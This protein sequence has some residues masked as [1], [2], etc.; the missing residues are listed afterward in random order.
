MENNLIKNHTG[1]NFLMR[2]KFILNI[3]PATGEP[4]DKIKCSSPG[5]VASAVKLA[6]K[7]FKTW[8]FFTLSQ[9]IAYFK[10]ILKDLIAEKNNISRLITDEMGKVFKQS[11]IE[12]DDMIDSFRDT[13]DMVE[14]SFSM[15]Q[16]K[17]K[18][19]ISEIHRIPIG[20]A[21]II[22]PW[23]FP[24]AMPE[25]LLT[26]SILAGNTVVFKPSECTPLTGKAIFEVFHRYLPKGVI[27]LV[28][29]AD[30]VGECLIN[31]DID[32]IA[33]IGSQEV[34]KKI[35]QTAS[36]KLNRVILELGG[37]DP[38]IV[39]KDAN[40]RKAAEF[41]VKNSISNS[42]QVCVSV[43]RI[44]VDERI[45]HKFEKEVLSI[46][47]DVKVGSG[48]ENVDIGPMVNEIQRA[49]VIS[50]IEEARRKGGKLL[51]GGNIINRKGYFMEPTVLTNLTEKHDI[52]KEETF[53]PVVCI[54]KYRTIEEAI[55]KA[56][57]T[58]F[59]LGATIWTESH[60]KAI[61]IANKIEAGMIGI[62]KSVC[63]VKRTPW[64]GIKESGYG[65]LGSIEGLR[66]FTLPKKISYYIK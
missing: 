23:N 18:K 36:R 56:N 58:T 64:I 20:V 11:Q 52:M 45:A 1:I 14:E 39:M 15:T 37:K 38:M 34:G 27:N 47:K 49:H 66:Q 30:E 44:Y 17:H 59:G 42:G 12:F 26:P 5:E 32:M 3:N 16:Y 9:R 31:S 35:M 6:K 2:Q 50:Q 4:I 55:E 46:I 62:N 28:Q 7:A 25:W 65:F 57:N 54:Q 29:G 24:A 13:L 63:G 51:Y 10:K 48:Y 19:L 33:F 61:E 8:G 22:T 41:A 53:G 43:E 40:A 60:K 21:A